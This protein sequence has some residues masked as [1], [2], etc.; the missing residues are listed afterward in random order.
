MSRLASTVFAS[1][2]LAPIV[3]LAGEGHDIH[4]VELAIYIGGFLVI[5][6]PLVIILRPV[7]VNGLKQRHLTVKTE[8]DEASRIFAEAEARMAS[9]HDRVA[10]MAEEIERLRAEFREQA[11][12]E[13]KALAREGEILAEKIRKDSEFRISQ[14]VKMARTELA[15]AVVARAFSTVEDRLGKTAGGP[16]SESLVSQVVAEVSRVD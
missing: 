3:A 15:D 9:A 2:L 1:I 10:H 8:I 7:V 16:V 6:I 14:S 13:R 5:I 4:N 11:E 12:V